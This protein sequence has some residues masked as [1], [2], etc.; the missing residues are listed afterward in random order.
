MMRG[1]PLVVFV[2]SLKQDP[3]LISSV[4]ESVVL[5]RLMDSLEGSHGAFR[6]HNAQMQ[7]ETLE[8]RERRQSSNSC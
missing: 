4:N 8:I 7:F 5:D 2:C 3:C 6:G 1:L